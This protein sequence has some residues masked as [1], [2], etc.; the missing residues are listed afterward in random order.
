[1]KKVKLFLMPILMALN[2]NPK[3]I[4][5]ALFKGLTF[6]R[7]L[8]KVNSMSKALINNSALYPSLDPPPADFA[9]EVGKLDALEIKE[10]N[11]LQQLKANTEAKLQQKKVVNDIVVDKYCNQIQNTPGVT[12]ENIKKVGFGVKNYDDQQS[13]PVASVTNSKP[14]IEEIDANHHLQQTL[15]IHNSVSGLIAIPHDAKR[16]DVY[17]SFGA[18]MPTDVK[19]MTYGG[20]ATKG[21]FTYHFNPEDLGKDVWYICVYVP[22]K[23]G[24]MGELS[25]AVKKTV[26]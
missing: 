5:T 13:E 1:M 10:K 8:I 22:R 12:V 26:S 24:V 17:L 3:I 25:G 4:V 19:K 6:A 7:F 23:K 21:K 14:T 18:E 2:V 9:T 15:I 16:L 11:I 20:S